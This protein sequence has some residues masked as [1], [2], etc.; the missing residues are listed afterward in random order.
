MEAKVEILKAKINYHRDF[1]NQTLMTCVSL[2]IAFY[3]LMN[4][5]IFLSGMLGLMGAG[6]LILYVQSGIRYN[7]RHCELIDQ[8]RET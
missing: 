5:N 7:K 2:L 3:I 4:Q 8:L 1:S 6:F